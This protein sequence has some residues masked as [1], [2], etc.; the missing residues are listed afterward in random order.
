MPP[1]RKEIREESE[2][3]ESIASP[4]S[5]SSAS[6]AS[7]GGLILSAEQLQQVLESTARSMVSFMETR[8]SATS[9]PTSSPSPSVRTKIDIPKWKDGDIPS[10]FLAKYE[11]AL[12]HNGVSKDQ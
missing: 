11:Q 8:L 6:S 12:L 9:A 1:K 5:G 4:G 3:A 10:E 2:D 7:S